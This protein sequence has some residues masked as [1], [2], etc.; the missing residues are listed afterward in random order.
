MAK[1]TTKDRMVLSAIT[2]LR[3]QGVT[4]VTIDAVL[5]HSGAPRGSVYHHFPGGRAEL[6]LTAGRT[7]SDYITGLL[8]EA[9]TASSPRE[10]VETFVEFWRRTLEASD[11]RAGCPVVALATGNRDIPEADDLVRETF[12]TWQEH[13]RRLLREAG[14]DAADA[15][16]IIAA[17]EG[18]VVLCKGLRSPAP[19]DEVSA[20]LARWLAA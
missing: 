9:S 3:E 13:L 1:V 15:T 2:L 6:V 12:A 11:Y 4:G 20:S 16:L 7:A 5:A 17:I 10:A 18:A 19:L 8:R 14:R